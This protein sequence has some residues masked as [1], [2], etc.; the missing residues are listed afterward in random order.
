MLSYEH[1]Y[2]ENSI[3]FFFEISLVSKTEKMSKKNDF[4]LIYE[5]PQ[6]WFVHMNVLSP[7][8]KFFWKGKEWNFWKNKRGICAKII[9]SHYFWEVSSIS[10]IVSTWRIPSKLNTIRNHKGNEHV[11]SKP[12]TKID[13]LFKKKNMWIFCTKFKNVTTYS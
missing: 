9:F 10:H 1:F 12:A 3:S 4:A 11:S 7:C 6:N 8:F 13:F 2:D 5:R